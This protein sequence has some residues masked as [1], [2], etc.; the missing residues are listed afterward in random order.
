[1]IHT[2]KGFSLV[3]EAEVDISL[4]FP[5]FFCDPVDVGILKFDLHVINN[6]IWV[7]SNT[8]YQRVVYA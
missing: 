5:C 2:V 7:N 8:T 3:S 4:E 1:M 6:I